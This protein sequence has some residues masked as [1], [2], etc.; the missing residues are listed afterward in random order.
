[1]DQIVGLISKG[2]IIGRIPQQGQLLDRLEFTLDI[3]PDRFIP[4]TVEWPVGLGLEST[5]LM[6]CLNKPLYASID[7]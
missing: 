6:H 5:G 4:C 7:D 2:T 3:R 1:M